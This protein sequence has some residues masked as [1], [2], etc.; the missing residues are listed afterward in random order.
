MNADALYGALSTVAGLIGT[1]G[2]LPQIRRTL[3]RKAVRDISPSFLAQVLGSLT[4]YTIFGIGKREWWFLVG[5]G[6]QLVFVGFMAALW[7]R[8]RNN[9]EPSTEAG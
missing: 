3:R 5:V 4:L 6:A 7:W 8:Y 9:P 1:L 2:W